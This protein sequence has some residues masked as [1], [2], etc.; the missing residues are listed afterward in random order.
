MEQ[1]ERE[2]EMLVAVRTAELA[3]SEH[4]LRAILSALFDLVFLVDEDGRY[5]EILSAAS[6]LPAK[7]AEELRGR[8][9]HD[10]FPKPTADTFLSLVRATLQTQSIQTMGYLRGPS[11][12]GAHPVRSTV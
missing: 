5:L 8:L 6:P 1:R 4:R 3:I 12:L 9:F 11:G 10:V 7:S 2:L